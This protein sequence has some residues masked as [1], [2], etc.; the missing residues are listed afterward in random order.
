MT[1]YF[2][3]AT[4]IAANDA[5]KVLFNTGVIKVYAGTQPTDANTSIGSPTLLGT[6]TMAATAF[7][8]SAGT[9]TTPNRSA[10]ATA[11]NPADVTAVATGTAAFFRAFKSDGTTV[12][13]D[14]S[15]TATG[16]GGDMTL[17]DTSITLGET[18][19]VSSLTLATPE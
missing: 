8:T 4:A 11:T 16:S 10:L 15:V 7:G 17:T 3:D 9:G 19:S 13:C 5:V 12:I 18:M 6:F 14:G 1:L 2:A